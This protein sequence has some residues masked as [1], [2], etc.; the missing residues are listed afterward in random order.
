M[1]HQHEKEPVQDMGQGH[2]DKGLH[3]E[4]AGGKDKEAGGGRREHRASGSH[5]Y[6]ITGTHNDEEEHTTGTGRNRGGSGH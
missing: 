5:E 6:N 4:H 1:G 3:G 2:S